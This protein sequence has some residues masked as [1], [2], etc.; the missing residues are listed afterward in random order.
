MGT[1]NVNGKMP[2]Q[3]L[4]AWI[5]GDQGDGQDRLI[6]PLNTLSLSSGDGVKGRFLD[7]ASFLSFDVDIFC[8]GEG[9]YPGAD[10]SETANVADRKQE[11]DPYITKNL[12]R[13]IDLDPDLLVFGFQELDQSTEAFLYLT[14]TRE[15]AWI[16]AI[17]AGLGEKG[18]QYEKVE[19]ASTFGSIDRLTHIPELSA[20]I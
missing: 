17:L 7:F 14:S 16:L 1:F 5:R 2:S 4:S 13:K 8:T 9:S 10:A 12:E 20:S 6:S 11:A 18:Q 15:D 3:D 19:I